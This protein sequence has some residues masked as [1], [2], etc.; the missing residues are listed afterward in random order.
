[1][2]GRNA[3]NEGEEGDGKQRKEGMGGIEGMKGMERREGRKG[4]CPK[5]N[6]IGQKSIKSLKCIQRQSD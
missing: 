1:M 3:I 5:D 4:I 6:L 2:K